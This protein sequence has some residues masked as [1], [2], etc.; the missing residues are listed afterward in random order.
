[1]SLDRN[2]YRALEDIVGPENV[3]EEPAIMDSYAWRSGMMA[4][5]TKFVPRF[6]AV[7]LP[8]DT[9]EVQAIVR[10]CNRH[11]VQ[12]KASGT[13]WGMSSSPGGPGVIQLDLRRMNR[14]LEINERHQYA[15]VEPYVIGGQLQ[16]EAM[17]RGLNFSV[18]GAGAQTSALPLAAGTG[19]GFMSQTMGL[20]ERNV[21]GV[22]WVTPAGDVIGLGTVGSLGAWF[23]GD[24]PGP[25]LRSLL[26][27]AV[28]SSGGIG[29]FTKASTKLYHWPGPQTM[30]LTGISPRYSPTASLDNFLVRFFSFPSADIMIKAARKI[31]ESEIA[32][33]MSHS[34]P[35]LSSSMTTSNEE[36]LE[37][38]K[39]FRESAQG[40][41]FIVVLAGNSAGEFE[42]KKK[43]LEKIVSEHGGESLKAIED[44]EIGKGIIWR[45]IRMT[46]AIREA[47]RATGVWFGCMAG[48]NFS[49]IEAKYVQTAARLKDEMIGKGLLFDGDKG[50]L[51]LM[52]WPMEQGH[53]G[54][55]EIIFRYFPNSD[56]VEA[57]EHFKEQCRRVTLDEHAG[58]PYG[59]SGDELV[60]RFGPHYSNYHTWLRKM[61]KA[62]DPQ[63]VSE[64]TNYV[65]A[66]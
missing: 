21:L 53:R 34:V 9:S 32:L 60:D 43:V 37:L 6:E 44:P 52:V 39:K 65:S 33:Q 4:G 59:V 42:Y 49:A 14:I 25:S 26:R 54:L 17:K 29:V 24:G 13:G 23:S 27:G 3:S 8:K 58:G 48:H 22:E 63:G 10:L 38:L 62:F 51:D 15:V 35:M 41:G 7:V 28:S 12:F 66:W 1:M 5:T 36:D 56:T 11:G 57:I 19:H 30:E 50:V 46:T 55:A 20:A 31:G 61:K 16:A 47:H 64:S 18:N 2:V 45:F 40:P